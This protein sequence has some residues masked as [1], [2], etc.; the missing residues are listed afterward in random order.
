MKKMVKKDVWELMKSLSMRAALPTLKISDSIARGVEFRTDGGIVINDYLQATNRRIYAAGDVRLQLKGI[1][2]ADAATRVGPENALSSGR[3]RLSALT[4]PMVT[5]TDP[6]IAHVGMT[7]SEAGVTGMRVD[8][9]V[10]YLRDF[11]R[12]VPD[13]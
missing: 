12:A 11:D 9:Y 6:G 8:R 7:N 1:H 3:G 4:I 10:R 5:Y 2:T 13:V